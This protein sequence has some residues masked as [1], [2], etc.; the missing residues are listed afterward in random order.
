MPSS[1][2]QRRMNMQCRFTTNWALAMPVL[3]QAFR[4]RTSRVTAR[5]LGNTR[6][7][8]LADAID[9]FFR[10]VSCGGSCAPANIWWEKNG[11]VYR[12]QLRL[13]SSASEQDQQKTMIEL[14]NSAI[15]AG[16]R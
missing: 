3:R 7:V 11:T 14:A 4:L 1:K 12:F 9:G 6:P 5:D 13:S 8:K 15:N 2:R 16:P 10:P